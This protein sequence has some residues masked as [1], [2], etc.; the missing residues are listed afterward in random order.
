MLKDKL[1]SAPV[2]LL[3]DFSKT[4][5]VTTDASDFALDAVLSQDQGCGEQPI[6]YESRKLSAAELNYPTHEK[7]LLAIVH[8]IKVW[9]PYLEGKTFTVETDHASLEYIKSQYQLSCRQARW[10][11]LLQANDFHV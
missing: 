9:R 8:A 7:E 3:P 5:T 6:A 2:L 1:T 4:F 10:M 11:E